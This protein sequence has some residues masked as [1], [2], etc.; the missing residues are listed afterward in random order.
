MQHT[1]LVQQTFSKWTISFWSG[2]PVDVQQSPGAYLSSSCLDHLNNWLDTS[3]TAVGLERH[4]GEMSTHFHPIS[5]F[6]CAWTLLKSYKG[7]KTAVW[8]A[9]W[10]FHA[11]LMATEEHHTNINAICKAPNVQYSK[12]QYTHCTLH[13][14]QIEET[15]TGLWSKMN[16]KASF[17]FKLV[18][19]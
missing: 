8:K 19:T 10:F 4:V 11:K 5:P 9:E 1:R 15:N 6:C 17:S 2:G 7:N 18:I 16:Q 13:Y 12:V 3:H 14:S